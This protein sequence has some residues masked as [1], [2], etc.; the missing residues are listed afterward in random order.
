MSDDSAGEQSN[1]EQ[2]K[3]Q[4]KGLVRE[5]SQL[6]K[7]GTEADQYYTAVLQR[8]ISA[9]AAHG[10]AVWSLTPDRKLR[11][12]SQIQVDPRL[13]DATSED[14]MRHFRLLQQILTSGEPRLVPPRSSFGEEGQFGNPTDTLLV[15]APLRTNEAIEGVIEIFQRPDSVPQAQK[16]YLRFLVEMSDIIGDWM[17]SRKLQHMT[18]RH[19]LWTQIDSFT[20]AIHESLD[21]RHTAYTIANEGRRLVECDRLSVA[22]RRA[23][24]D[25]IEAISG[26]DV[27]DS[28]SNVVRLLRDLT[29]RVT[30]TGEPLWYDGNSNDLPPQVET[31][32]HEY[33]DECHTKSI[34]VLPLRRPVVEVD[35]DKELG[36]DSD[37]E[38][39]KGDVIGALIVEHIETRPARA[40]VQ[41]KADLVSHHSARAL[42]NSLEHN[43]LF[44]MP[45]WRALGNATWLVRAKTLPKTIAV[46]TGL[47]LASLILTLWQ[48]DFELKAPAYLEPEET[49]D[50]FFHGEGIV[51]NVLVEHGDVVHAGDVLVECRDPQLDQELARQQGARDSARARL[52]AAQDILDQAH[53]VSAQEETSALAEA[54]QARIDLETANKQVDVLQTRQQQLT[55]YSPCD[56]EVISWDVA[57]TLTDRPVQRGDRAIKLAKTDG[58]WEL[59]VKMPERSMGHVHLAAKSQ[60]P[61]L[62]V[63]WVLRSNPDKVFDG[64]VREIYPSAE[65]DEQEATPVVKLRV[66]VDAAQIPH[67]RPD[68]TATAKVVCGRRSLGYVL[69]HQLWEWLQIN[70]FFR[71]Q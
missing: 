56:G 62:P 18:D 67:L 9:L 15:L 46:I 14:S 37:D 13:L 43:N 32:L 1:V 61:E 26:Q 22:V 20:Q 16:G 47:L 33:V 58:E 39:R 50:V 7:S 64:A 28:R 8:I 19:A 45:V 65:F 63:E 66:A 25:E 55:V 42:S 17:K 2:T 29:R 54:E 24:K 59:V 60:G 10:G 21:L 3:Q 34:A 51:R 31:S 52:V 27:L 36:A 70:L 11:I 57:D 44:L 35:T 40:T 30:A 6:S 71:F 49:R 38:S 69:F 53:R 23:G 41:P 4:I 48:S 5:I 68:L 12:D